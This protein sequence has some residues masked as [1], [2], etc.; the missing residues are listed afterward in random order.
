MSK[1]GEDTFK[2]LETQIEVATRYLRITPVE[3]YFALIAMR[4]FMNR[5]G[6]DQTLALI[7]E[8]GPDS[9]AKAVQLEL[10]QMSELW[11]HCVA[12][13]PPPKEKLAGLLTDIGMARRFGR[14]KIVTARLYN[15]LMRL[16]I[17]EDMIQERKQ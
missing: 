3:K 5:F 11:A 16:R 7:K 14:D 13:E 12:I 2:K 8:R 10:T 17:R 6:Y 1:L 15:I 9:M 4:L